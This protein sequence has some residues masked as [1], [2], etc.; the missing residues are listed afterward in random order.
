MQIRLTQ[1]ARIY[2]RKGDALTL[3]D[4][5]AKVLINR[6]HA[7]SCDFA[8]L[9]DNPPSAPAPEAAVTPP[10]SPRR[11]GRPRKVVETPPNEI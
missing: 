11:R 8:P 1:D 6:G 2:L 4:E 10:P 3:P 7:E 9:A 5:V